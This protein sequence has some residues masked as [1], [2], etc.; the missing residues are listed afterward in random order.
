MVR[1]YSYTSFATYILEL[2]K[3]FRETFLD[4]CLPPSMKILSV[5]LFILPI[6]PCSHGPAGFTFELGDH[7]QRKTKSKTLLLPETLSSSLAES[8]FIET[9]PCRRRK[10]QEVFSYIPSRGEKSIG[11]SLFLFRA[12]IDEHL[13]NF[14]KD[15]LKPHKKEVYQV[16]CCHCHKYCSPTHTSHMNNKNREVLGRCQGIFILISVFQE[17]L[18]I[19]VLQQGNSAKYILLFLRGSLFYKDMTFMKEK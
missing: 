14:L 16:T 6:P 3:C 17:N 2:Q 15:S 1:S 11:V 13:S 4:F 8:C 9:W 10:I 18:Y 7:K 5:S 19:L 12:R